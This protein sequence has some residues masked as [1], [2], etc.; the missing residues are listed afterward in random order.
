MECRDQILRI[1]H[2]LGEEIAN[3]NSELQYK[4]NELLRIQ[5]KNCQY[6]EITYIYVCVCVCVV[7]RKRER[8]T[9]YAIFLATNDAKSTSF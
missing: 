9:D 3:R 2:F 7:C 8:D 6:S 4:T 1:V 5:N